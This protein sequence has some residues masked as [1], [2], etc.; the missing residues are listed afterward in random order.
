MGSN[1]KPAMQPLACSLARLDRS[2]ARSLNE[3][4]D[5]FYDGITFLFSHTLALGCVFRSLTRTFVLYSVIQVS[6]SR[7]QTSFT[8]NKT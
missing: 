2:L 8:F 3:F 6:F 4:F 7:L 5:S 1:S